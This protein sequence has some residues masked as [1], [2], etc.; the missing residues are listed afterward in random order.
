MLPQTLS[1]APAWS[2]EVAKL[3]N[4]ASDRDWRLLATRLGYSAEDVRAWATQPDPCLSLLDE[5]FATHSTREATHAVLKTL[6]E[7]NR[8]DAAAVVQGALKSVGQ[9][10]K[11]L[12]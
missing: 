1:H 12:S 10:S 5:W 8:T 7:I 6:T 11:F 3:L 9:K 4:P 2:R